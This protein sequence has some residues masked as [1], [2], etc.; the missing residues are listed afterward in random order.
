MSSAAPSHYLRPNHAESTPRRVICFDVESRLSRR[1]SAE[2][3]RFRLAVASFDRRASADDPWALPVWEEFGDP[4]DLWEW[5]TERTTTK[6]TTWCYAHNLSYDLLVSGGIPRLVDAG[7]ECTGFGAGKDS[8]WMR[9]R[10]GRYRLVLCDLGAWLPVPLERIG[11]WIDQPKLPMPSPFDSKR[12]WLTYCHRDVSILRTAVL[13]LIDW[14]QRQE[15]GSWALT[16]ASQAWRAWRHRFLDRRLLVHRSEAKNRI[17]VA[18]YFGGRNEARRWGELSGGPWHSLDLQAAYCHTLATEALPIGEGGWRMHADEDDLGDRAKGRGLIAEVEVETDEPVVPARIRTGVVW[19][20]GR[21]RT[22]L[23]QP[24]IEEAL[25]AGAKV[26]FERALSYRL[27]PVC[28][29]FAEW[30]LAGLYSDQV[31]WHPLIRSVLKRWSRDLAGKLG[32]RHRSWRKAGA[33]EGSRVGVEP[34][35]V[36]GERYARPGWW[37]GSELFVSESGGLGDNAMPAMAA[38]VTS[39]VRA[40]LWRLGEWIGWEHVAY[41]DTD[42]LVVD[43]EAYER[44]LE[45]VRPG[46]PGQLQEKW[47]ASSMVVHGVKDIEVDD[48]V[49]V[50]G[51]PPKSVRL[52]ERRWQV[53]TWPGLSTHL[54]EGI[55]EGFRSRVDVVELAAPYRKGWVTE[56]GQVVPLELD[57]VG[58]SNTVVPWSM[59]R[60]HEAGMSLAPEAYPDGWRGGPA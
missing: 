4:G 13:A 21:F 2:D 23:P 42:E 6:I 44:A 30:V 53:R 59:T 58:G 9:W 17:E 37:L 5:I 43:H 33:F 57:I 29:S 7:W 55:T 27:E 60:W 26:T 1:Q 22:V 46:E 18:G 19:P 54:S 40:R 35:L 56:G 34:I 3:H 28:S 25:E 20:V 16:A 49:H 52:G 47:Q 11:E 38:W 50:K 14:V 15:L 32:Q 45:L 10:N 39:T 51:I 41:V 48:R 12:K 36:D 24:E 8:T 31:D